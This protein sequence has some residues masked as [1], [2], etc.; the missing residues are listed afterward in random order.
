MMKTNKSSDNRISR[1]MKQ[2]ISL[3]VLLSLAAGI[4]VLTPERAKAAASQ[5]DQTFG[6]GGKVFYI[7]VGGSGGYGDIEIQPDG[8]AV[9]VG[10]A[11]FEVIRFNVNG[12]P[13]N[14]FD[15]DGL[16]QVPFPGL[17]QS[18]ALAI[19]TD[20]KIVVAGRSAGDLA[21]AR[22]NSDGSLD[23]TFDGDGIAVLVLPD[24]QEILDIAIQPDGKIIMGGNT[25]NSPPAQDFMVVRFNANGTP[26]AAF[27]TGGNGVFQT[28]FNDADN[29]SSIALQ[30][31]GKIVAGG[32]TNFGDFALLRLTATGSLDSTFDTDGKL[33][34]SIRESDFLNKVLI[35]PD[36]KIIATGSTRNAGQSVDAAVVRYNPNGTLDTSFDVDG[37]ATTDDGPFEETFAA[38]LQP[39]G[40][41][42]VTERRDFNTSALIRF[43]SN[44]SLDTSFHGDG[45]FT[46]PASL[47]TNT[48]ANAVALQSDGKIIITGKVGPDLFL[49]RLLGDPR[50]VVTNNTGIVLEDRNGTNPPFLNTST[51]NVSNLPGTITKVRVSL[52]KITHTFPADLDIML[53]S[54]TGVRTMLMSDT[55]GGSNQ[56]FVNKTIIID[57]SAAN[58][59]PVPA[60]E[61]FGYFKPTNLAG[62]TTLEPGGIDVFPSPGP[63]SQNYGVGNLDVF[64][65][66]KPNG[67]WKLYAVD[68]EAA[69]FGGFEGWTLDLTTTT[70]RLNNLG[71]DFDG[72]GRT[73]ISIF[74]PSVG[75]WWLNRSST[76]VT[77]AARF[78]QTTDIITP[79]DFT[80]DGKTDIA[81][82]RPSTGFWFILNSER[83]FFSYPFG[84]SGDIPAPADFDGDGITDS[85]VFR[86]SNSTWYIRRSSDLGA[87]I[88]QFGTTGDK[89]VTADYDGDGLSD[90]AIFRPSDGS[91]WY[92]QSSNGQ[93][94]VYRF[95]VSTDKPVPADY[96]GDGKTDLAVF[97]PSTGEWF[98]QRSEDNSFFSFTFGTSGDLPAPGDYD[99]NGIADATVF[100]P[101]TVTWFSLTQ[102]QGTIFTTFGASGDKPVPAAFVP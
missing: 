36:G 79:G 73:D 101:S 62:S 66:T 41:I 95:G 70:S 76:A 54:P 63:G 48:T 60:T 82:F 13:D 81:F 92:L 57:Q 30:T 53:E 21:V 67:T 10:S 18:N 88:V 7:T 8:K 37:I 100:R 24:S 20:G 32:S 26:D 58:T 75:E 84:T 19:Q 5:F 61:N 17:S 1:V 27:G 91:W 86:P 52:N 11:G 51:V 4:L 56:G 46:F 65:G 40:K 9:I 89:P 96:T 78:G 85:A 49:S 77:V 31:D 47:Y 34:T 83:A 93:F 98:V 14:T 102:T 15:G 43:N 80:G 87:T 35:Q 44:G 55:G 97:R 3:A 25:G 2:A 39:D 69:D 45:K 99:G 33:T 68:D 64:N 72:D 59:I 71:A 42:I 12:T 23:S 16:A 29:F 90:I 22:L 28:S 50:A 6:S 74:R 38:V 94:K